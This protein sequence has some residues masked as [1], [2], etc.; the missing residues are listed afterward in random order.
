MMSSPILAPLIKRKVRGM[1]LFNSISL[2]DHKVL[3]QLSFSLQKLGSN[4][5]KRC[6]YF[7]NHCFMEWLIHFVDRNEDTIFQRFGS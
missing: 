1:N 6:S 3:P 5:R 4:Q 2:I 7:L